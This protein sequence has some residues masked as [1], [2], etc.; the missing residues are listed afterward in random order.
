PSFVSGQMPVYTREALEAK[1]QGK[2]IVKCVVTTS[3]ALTGCR[4]VKGLPYMDQA[5]LA[6]MAT[7]RYTPVLSNGQPVA[8]EYVFTL[9]LVLP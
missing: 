9:R 6:A 8:V 1:V 7:Q 3:G 4:I 2:V 5:V